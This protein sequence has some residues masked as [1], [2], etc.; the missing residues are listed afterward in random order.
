[1]LARGAVVMM[2]VLVQTAEVCTARRCNWSDPSAVV[3]AERTGRKDGTGAGE[4]YDHCRVLAGA[5]RQAVRHCYG[6]GC[7]CVRFRVS[8]GCVWVCGRVGVC[9][10]V[11][12]WPFVRQRASGGMRRK[13]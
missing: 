8:G 1:M 2:K 12:V 7:D 5:R 10:C 13:G 4:G 11:C 9:V 3:L 6:G